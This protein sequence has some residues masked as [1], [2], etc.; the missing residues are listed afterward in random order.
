MLITSDS[1]Q[2]KTDN[3]TEV[4]EKKEEEVSLPSVYH[5]QVPE[6]YTKNDLVL[7]PL[8]DTQGRQSKTPRR[9]VVKNTKLKPIEDHANVI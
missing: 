7:S 5:E 6:F 4:V 2:T 1:A 3:Q 9:R 8:R